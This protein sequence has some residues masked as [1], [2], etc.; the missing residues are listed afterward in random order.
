[1]AR[2]AAVGLVAALLV[3][4]VFADSTVVAN[5]R[6]FFDGVALH[7]KFSLPSYSVSQKNCFVDTGS[8]NDH[9]LVVGAG[10]VYNAPYPAGQSHDYC[11]KDLGVIVW[12]PNGGPAHTQVATA[13]PGGPRYCRIGC[14]TDEYHTPDFVALDATAVNTPC[15]ATCYRSGGCNLCITTPGQTCT[16]YCMNEVVGSSGGRCKNPGSTNIDSCCECFFF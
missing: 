4:G 5:T 10:R 13:T 12:D 8:A 11:C 2:A 7:G 6:R 14:P 9:S 3:A 15:S 1:M 16:E